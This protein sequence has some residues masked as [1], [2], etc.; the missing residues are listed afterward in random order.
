MALSEEKFIK[1]NQFDMTNEDDRNKL[2]NTITAI[3]TENQGI[4]I[5]TSNAH[6][7]AEQF[8]IG[9]ARRIAENAQVDFIIMNESDL[10]NKK[11]ESHQSFL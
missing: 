4:T 1:L 7:R 11:N 10:A 9:S 5:V 2:I 6:N 8:F 3:A